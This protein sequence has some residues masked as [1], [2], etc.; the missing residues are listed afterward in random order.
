M[1]I[2]LKELRETNNCL[3]IIERAKLH[4][5]ISHTIKLKT[6]VNELISIFV[7]SIKTAKKNAEN[8]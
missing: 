8:K 3:K 4:L 7:A 2:C 1:K 5:N 6:E